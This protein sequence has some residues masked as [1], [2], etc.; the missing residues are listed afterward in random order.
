MHLNPS[1][2]DHLLTSDGSDIEVVS[3]FKYLGGYTD[4]G[5]DMDV[6]IAQS[7]S[8]F[9][10]LQKVWKAP[11]QKDTKTKVFQACIETILLY[12]SDSWTLNA[13]RRKRL[14]GT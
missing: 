8:A 7:W 2:D 10:S 9:H 12:G 11:I 6:R 14:D 4:S 1:T 13:A 3:D 5:H